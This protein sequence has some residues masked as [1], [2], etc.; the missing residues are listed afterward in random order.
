MTK[1]LKLTPCVRPVEGDRLRAFGRSLGLRAVII[2]GLLAGALAQPL[3]AQPRQVRP[4]AGAQSAAT[5]DPRCPNREV[6]TVPGAAFSARPLAHDARLVVFPYSRDALFPV[7]A[8]FNRYVHFEFESGERIVASYIND[9]TEWEM[10]VSNTERDVL[11]RPK[12]KGASG[13]MVTITDRRRYQIE[14]TEVSMCPGEWRYQ[15]VS[16]T[17]QDGSYENPAAIE[18]LR[19]EASRPV[20]QPTA[21]GVPTMSTPAAA[22]DPLRLS[23]A[24]VNTA[25]DIDGDKDLAPSAVVDDGRRT[26]LKFPARMTLRPVLFAVAADGKAEAV[27]YVTADTHFLVNRVFEHGLMLKLGAREARIRNRSSHCG[28]FDQACRRLDASNIIEAK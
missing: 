24:S 13:S 21:G 25:Y 10:K 23:L 2:A 7:N 16:W 14:L 4:P 19:A 28:W 20:P 9:E 11:V 17:H 8:V 1:G 12:V 3:A 26:I 27:E 6:A 18:Q 22:T 5:A 15:R